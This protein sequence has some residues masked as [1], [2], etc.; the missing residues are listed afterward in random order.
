[1]GNLEVVDG[2]VILASGNDIEG[3]AQLLWG[4]GI[5]SDGDHVVSKLLEGDG[6]STVGDTLEESFEDGVTSL[7]VKFNNTKTRKAS[8]E[9][10]L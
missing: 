8:L 9:V 2:D 3:I 5:D 1:L 6:L 4:D 7:E 10:E